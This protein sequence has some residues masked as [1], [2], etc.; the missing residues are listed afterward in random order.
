MEIWRLVNYM[1]V[2][3]DCVLE[4][5]IIFCKNIEWKKAI[6]ANPNEFNQ[7]RTIKINDCVFSLMVICY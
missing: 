3:N 4:F 1:Q 7:L 6:K 5:K 2:Y